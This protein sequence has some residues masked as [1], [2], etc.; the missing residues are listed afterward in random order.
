MSNF[1]KIAFGLVLATLTTFW[2]AIN[3]AGVTS[4][5]SQAAV[6]APVD[7]PTV[8]KT[9]AERKEIQ[10]QAQRKIQRQKTLAQI[11]KLK[12]RESDTPDKSLRELHQDSNIVD[13]TT[14]PSLSVDIESLESFS[15]DPD[16]PT[17]Y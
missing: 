13:D 3:P 4:R 10:N 14:A 1:D 5:P 8:E 2:V 7:A 16:I 9:R 12:R 15:D 11:E 6:S 17:F